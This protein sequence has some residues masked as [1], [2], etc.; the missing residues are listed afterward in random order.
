MQ[1]VLVI[2][3]FQRTRIYIRNYTDCIRRYPNKIFSR[4]GKILRILSNCVVAWTN[5]AYYYA[6]VKTILDSILELPHPRRAPLVTMA[7]ATMFVA[8]FERPSVTIN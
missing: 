5:I 8:L 4:Y 3:I 1:A 2:Y 7:L 6:A